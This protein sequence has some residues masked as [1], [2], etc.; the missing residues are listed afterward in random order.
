M[1]IYFGIWPTHLYIN[2]WPA[3]CIG[4]WRPKHYI[5]KHTRMKNLWYQLLVH[6]PVLE[7][8]Y[9]IRWEMTPKALHIKPSHFL[10]YKNVKAID[11]HQSILLVHLFAR[12]AHKWHLCHQP[13][14]IYHWFMI[15]LN[16]FY[17]ITYL[18]TI[19]QQPFME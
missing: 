1:I 2:C 11:L 7:K 12:H 17:E 15:V 5:S 10:F 3:N 18:F 14:F 4:E 16:F 8:L 13:C 19:P 9:L 6:Q